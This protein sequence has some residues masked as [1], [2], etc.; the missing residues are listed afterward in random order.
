MGNKMHTEFLGWNLLKS[1][2]LVDREENGKM[3]LTWRVVL[4]VGGREA[5]PGPCSMASFGVGCFGPSRVII[6]MSIRHTRF[7]MRV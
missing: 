7:I 5:G 3:I 2:Q 1:G 6:T 4:R